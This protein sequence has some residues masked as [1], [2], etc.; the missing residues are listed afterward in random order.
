MSFFSDRSI[1]DLDL[2]MPL[3]LRMRSLFGVGGFEEG[4]VDFFPAGEGF[5]DGIEGA[6]VAMLFLFRFIGALL[7]YC[8]C[9]G[10]LQHIPIF[11]L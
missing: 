2:C 1:D 3:A 4:L 9:I 8:V 7:G 10:S 11:P 6:I 5:D